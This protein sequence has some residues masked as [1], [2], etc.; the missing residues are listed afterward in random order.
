[1]AN[2]TNAEFIERVCKSLRDGTADIQLDNEG[3]FV[4]YTGMF[5]SNDSKDILESPD[6]NFI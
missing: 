4:I 1:M 6:P 3:Q 5:S 2:I